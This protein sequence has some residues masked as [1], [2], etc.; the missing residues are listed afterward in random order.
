M[1]PPPRAH[2]RARSGE[3]DGAVAGGAQGSVPDLGSACGLPAEDQGVGSVA[4]SVL[5]SEDA[6]R[7]EGGGPAVEACTSA[8][9]EVR[10]RI[11]NE[12]DR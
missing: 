11:E 6:V 4:C 1:Q 12:N 3:E 8:G 2:P 9:S 10:G 7:L 5:G